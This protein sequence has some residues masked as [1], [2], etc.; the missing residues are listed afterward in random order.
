MSRHVLF[1]HDNRSLGGVGAMSQQIAQGLALRGWSIEHLHVS[2]V[3]ASLPAVARLARRAGVVLATQNFSASYVA[4][5]IAAACRRPWVMCVHGPI[6]EVLEAAP[7]SAAK[8]RLLHWTY[9]RA[10]VIACSSQASLDSLQRFHPVGMQGQRVEV[11]RNTAAP[12]FF[13]AARGERSPAHRLGFVGRLSPEKQPLL[14]AQMLRH[15]PQNYAL[16]VVGAGPLAQQLEESAHPEIAARR[17]HLHGLQR[18]TPDTYR[19]WLATVLCSSYEGYPLVLLESLASGVPVVST[20]IAPAVEM[21]ERHAPYMLARDGSP[22]GLAGA[23]VDLA[24]RDRA[25]VARDIAA[26]NRDHDPQQFVARWDELLS[27]AVGA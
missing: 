23:V 18:V 2:G 27:R 14:L 8:R 9:R 10:P 25:Q 3:A 24:R 6:T 7:P 26:I 12:A 5:G 22:A 13:E 4:A 15:L 16:D 21:L 1:V 17:L 20:P 11:I 19:Q